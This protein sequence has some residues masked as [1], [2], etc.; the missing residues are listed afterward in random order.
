MLSL[1]V[2][3]VCCRS[4][5][6]KEALMTKHPA[7]KFQSR[8]DYFAPDAIKEREKYLAEFIVVRPYNYA[9]LVTLIGLWNDQFTDGTCRHALWIAKP[10][11][12]AGAALD[13]TLHVLKLELSKV[14]THCLSACKVEVA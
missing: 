11:S 12:I 3:T 10:Q 13:P 7:T 5:T 6:P 1:T 8:T 4:P 14:Q 9:M 2:A